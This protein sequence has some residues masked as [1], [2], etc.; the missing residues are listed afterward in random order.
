MNNGINNGYEQ[1]RDKLI[2]VNVPRSIASVLPILFDGKGKTS[3]E[4]RQI[5]GL[6]TPECYMALNYLR[7]MKWV[8][9]FPIRNG[10]QGRPTNVYYLKKSKMDVLDEIC[11]K[12]NDPRYLEK[13]DHIFSVLFYIWGN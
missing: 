2:E 9:S 13:N 12:C 11:R 6:I 7:K 3:N 4:I 8:G 1:A 5:S 10:Q